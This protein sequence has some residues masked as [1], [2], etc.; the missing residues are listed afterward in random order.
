MVKSTSA[1]LELWMLLLVGVVSIAAC[2]YTPTTVSFDDENEDCG[3]E[4]FNESCD[5]NAQECP[6][7][8]CAPQGP[9]WPSDGRIGESLGPS[10][11]FEACNTF[12]SLDADNDA[13]KDSC[14][15]A[16][17]NAFRPQL[18]MNPYEQC[19]EREPY[20]AVRIMDAITKRVRIF[21]A[22]GYHRDCGN[23]IPQG[24]GH[25]GDSEFVILEVLAGLGGTWVLERMFTSAHLGSPVF[26]S[27]DWHDWTQ[28]FQVAVLGGRPKVVVSRNKH[29]NYRSVGS[30]DQNPLA[31]NCMWGFGQPIKPLPSQ[32]FSSGHNIGSSWRN[33]PSAGS[34]FGS[35][36]GYQNPPRPGVECFWGT[37]DFK[38]WSGTSGSGSGSYRPLLIAAGF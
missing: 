4:I 26:W 6:P 17:A 27:S 12:G 35:S 30:C 10:F 32:Y 15:L 16:L 29:A 23:L 9:G 7:G 14:E 33:L 31:D 37:E 21:Y 20:F 36:L 34:C 18:M 8:G 13:L 11:T 22:I 3:G 25:E 28:V 19:D 24:G 2:G 5:D 38:G 1:S